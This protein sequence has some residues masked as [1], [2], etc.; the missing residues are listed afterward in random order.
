VSAARRRPRPVREARAQ[1]PLSSAPNRRRDRHTP[2]ATC[3]AEINIQI[4]LAIRR[5]VALTSLTPSSRWPIT[6]VGRARNFRDAS[7]RPR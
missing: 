3:I 7:P 6:L 4:R 2:S 1:G 5:A